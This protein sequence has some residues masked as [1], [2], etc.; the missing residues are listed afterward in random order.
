MTLFFFSELL[1]V[2]EKGRIGSSSPRHPNNLKA[3]QKIVTTCAS[4]RNN[5]NNNNKNSVGVANLNGVTKIINITPSCTTTPITTTNSLNYQPSI[6]RVINPD[7]VKGATVTAK[8]EDVAAAAANGNADELQVL[9][10]NLELEGSLPE[11]TLQVY[12]QS[13]LL[14]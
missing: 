11:L 6:I 3:S 9:E 10:G 1:E 13:C 7:D 5:I 4:A 14:Y 12:I 8:V 2:L